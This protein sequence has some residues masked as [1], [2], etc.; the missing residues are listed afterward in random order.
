MFVLSNLISALASIT[1]IVLT[2]LQWLIIIWA[3]L[4][5]VS[6]DPNNPIVQLI[7]KLT[8]PVLY[9]VRKLLPFSLKFGFDISPFIA[10]LIIFFLQLFLVRTLNDLAVRIRMG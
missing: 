7:N 5:W 2:A 3:L 6:P 9:P 8:G 4:S 1:S 10:L